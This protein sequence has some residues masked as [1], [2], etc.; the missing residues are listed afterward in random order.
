VPSES[1]TFHN[2]YANVY[3]QP[4]WNVAFE[5]GTPVWDYFNDVWYLRK[6]PQKEIG[7]IAFSNGKNDGGIGWPQA[8]EFYRALQATRRP[9]IFVWG[10]SGHGQRA[11]LP[12]SLSDRYMPMDL[13]TDQSQPAFTG[14]SLDDDPGD[15]D[16][17]R[18]DP[19]GQSNLYL[20][21]E[22]DEI[23]DRSD[24]WEMTVG[25]VD[26]APQESCTV[27]ITPRRVQQFKLAPGTRLHWS[28][29][30][31][32]EDREV[33]SGQVTVDE[34]GLITLPQVMVGKGKHR[35]AVYSARK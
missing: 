15:G 26:K 21:W 29:K 32:S 9:H 22:T 31:L 5:D 30:S 23:V 16:P 34:L 33:Q 2:S 19:A 12:V 4:D 25:L 6:Y 18:G 14:C 3:G 28:T 24:A 35:I 1:P 8:V 7:L 27:N 17:N 10:Q 13:R 20:F 11:V